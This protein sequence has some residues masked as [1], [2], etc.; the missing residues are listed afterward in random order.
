MLR[1]SGKGGKYGG[2]VD[3]ATGHPMRDIGFVGHHGA[4]LLPFGPQFTKFFGNSSKF[5]QLSVV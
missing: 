1:C 5:C 2:I 4:A 3:H